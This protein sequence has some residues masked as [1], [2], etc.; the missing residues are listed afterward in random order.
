[1]FVVCNTNLS[2]PNWI[3]LPSSPILSGNEYYIAV[4]KTNPASFYRLGWDPNAQ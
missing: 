3:V 4:P 2:S 1:M